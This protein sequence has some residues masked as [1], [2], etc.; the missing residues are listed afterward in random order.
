METLENIPNDARSISAD[1]V[2]TICPDP[3]EPDKYLWLG[4]EGGGMNRFEISTGKCI[5]YNENNGL[6]NNVAYCILSDSLN[7]LWI[8][9]NKGLSCFDPLHKTFRTYTYDDGLPGSEFNRYAALRMQ[10]GELMFGVCRWICDFQPKR[11]IDKTACS[12]TSIYI[13]HYIQQ[14]NL[15]AK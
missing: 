1:G 11:S 7:N 2:L 13:S 5:N 15:L 12:S 3:V 4:T 9:T 8:S 10:N 14:Y 6:P